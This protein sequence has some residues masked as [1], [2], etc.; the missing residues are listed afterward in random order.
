MH[1][2]PLLAGLL[3]YIVA[4]RLV[5]RRF[6]GLPR[7]ILFAVLNVAGV[8]C[9][10]FYGSHEHFGLRFITYLALIVSLYLALCVFADRRGRW[11]WLAFFAPIAALI[12][13]RY[14]PSEV[15]V[16]LGHALGKSWRGPPQMIGISYLAFRC[17]R[18]VL[19]IRN[20]LVKKPNFLEYLNFAFF[21]PTMPVGPINTYANFRRGFETQ[22][23]S[24]A[25]AGEGAQLVHRSRGEGGRADEGRPGKTIP[26]DIPVGR[27]ALRILVGA[28]KYEFLANLCNQLTYSGLLL[29]DHPHHWLDLQVAMLFYY[30]YL[31]L[32][33]SGF[34]DLAI[35]AAALIGIPVPENF[36]NPFA[37]RNVKDFWNR[38]HLTLSLWMRDVVFSPLSKYFVGQFGLKLADHAIAL[39]IAVVFLLVGI[40]HGAGWNFAAYGA[41][42]ALGVVA[43]HYYTIFLK[44]KLGRERFKA[45]NQN[46]WI[47]AVAIGFTFCYCGASLIFFANTF[48]QIK[49]IFSLLR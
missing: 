40:W 2:L 7:E 38:W 30:L 32:N 13:V 27:A 11:P 26:Y 33:F 34:C 35:G 44:Q 10:L 20:G 9:F 47:R 21:L 15:Y 45:Y 14:V 12:A 48:P 17:S 8:F 1:T 3:G 39:A 43:N 19:E 25:G 28:V 5:L 23:P 31:Y 16:G 22:S 4:S 36:E 29:D 18:L 41:V 37:A 6:Q 42:H 46:R 24:P 49:Q